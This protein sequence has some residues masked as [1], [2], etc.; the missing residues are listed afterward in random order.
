[1]SLRFL[2]CVVLAALAAIPTSGASAA[3]RPGPGRP[4]GEQRACSRLADA[5]SSAAPDSGSM[6]ERL[7]KTGTGLVR[8]DVRNDDIGYGEGAKAALRQLLRWPDNAEVPDFTD[9]YV[10]VR[11]LGS[12]SSVIAAEMVAGTAHCQQLWFYELPGTGA[13]K[14]IA[15]PEENDGSAYCWGD[16]HGSYATLGEVG[17]IPTFAVE[18]FDAGNESIR[19]IARRGDA[20]HSYCRLNIAWPQRFAVAE[21]FCRGDGCAD[22]RAAAP[23][24][25][26]T[27]DATREVDKFW[28]AVPALPVPESHKA[29]FAQYIRDAVAKNATQGERNE[30]WPGESPDAALADAVYHTIAIGGHQ[31]TF[32]GVD[33]RNIAEWFVIWTEADGKSLEL[34]ELTPLD[35]PVPTLG[36]DA[37]TSYTRF[38][39]DSAIVPFRFGGKLLLARIGHGNFGWRE[40]DDYL[41]G[42]FALE[43]GSLL[44]V[45]GVVVRKERAP[46]PTVTRR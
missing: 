36:E 10:R 29:R 11:H 3:D 8:M 31:R 12:G 33:H 40:S 32:V 25:V 14:S 28:A 17:G 6:L 37:D 45:A 34:T 23:D 27:Y 39:F 7:T 30:V 13:A 1:M 35:T 16:S 9:W 18:N 4:E 20:W 2:V 19:L 42:L 46:G 41:V 24:L 21:E 44:P 38:G 43:G 5:I 22:L 26:K 15:P